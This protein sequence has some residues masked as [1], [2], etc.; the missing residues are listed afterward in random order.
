MKEYKIGTDV[1]I[2]SAGLW[3]IIISKFYHSDMLNLIR[4]DP[5]L[6]WNFPLW[7]QKPLYVVR[8]YDG[9]DIGSKH[10]VIHDLVISTG[11]LN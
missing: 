8:I 2:P 10:I 11:D 6:D 5:E 3:G 9:G 7:K 1:C 4:D